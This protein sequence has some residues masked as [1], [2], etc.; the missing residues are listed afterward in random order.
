MHTAKH[1]SITVQHRGNRCTVQLSPA[2]N[3]WVALPSPIAMQLLQSNT[4]MP[5][6]FQL[7]PQGAP[8]APSPAPP[9]HVAWVGD[10]CTVP[11]AVV[12]VPTALAACL[13]LLPGMPVT[14][15][16]C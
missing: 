11:G 8:G 5:A 15:Q 7:T 4:P 3:S 16:V 12:Q 13:Q 1:R 14:L 6:I 2:K 10:M 9:A